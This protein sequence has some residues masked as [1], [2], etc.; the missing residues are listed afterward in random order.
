MLWHVYCSITDLRL[1]EGSRM[2]KSILGTVI[3]AGAVLAA[4]AA[5]P[6]FADTMIC[7]YTLSCSYN[8]DVWNGSGSPPPGPWGTVNL[9]QS[10]ANVD[11]TIQ[12]SGNNVF[13]IGGA[14]QS[15]LWDFHNDPNIT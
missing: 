4:L 5:T 14:G 10:G 7:N 3:G 12:L 9:M 6:A 2:S 13:A 11:V 1:D 8:I 15:F